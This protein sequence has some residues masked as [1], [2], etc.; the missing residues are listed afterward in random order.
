MLN[1]QVKNEFSNFGSKMYIIGICA[2]LL[3]IPF[4]NIIASIIFFIYVIKSLG[5]IKRVYNQ[6]KD[7]HLQDYRIYYI[8]SFVVILVGAI[9]TSLL[10]INL[11]Y[12]INE[13]NEWVKNGDINKEDAQKWINEL[14]INFQTSLVTL[15][16]I[17]VLF[18]SILQTLAWHN[19][20]IFFKENN[21]MFPEIIANDAIRG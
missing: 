3:I 15:M 4:V 13:I 1:D 8:I 17:E 18:T 7:K 16:I 20:N 14:M 2:I 19:L 11:I 12:E 10:I 6:L 9:V 5:D 21:S